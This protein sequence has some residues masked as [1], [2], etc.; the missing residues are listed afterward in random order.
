MSDDA[1]SHFLG[2]LEALQ[3]QVI[4]QLDALN[5]RIE[6]TIHQ[7]LPQRRTAPERSPNAAATAGSVP[8]V[9]VARLA[10]GPQQP[11]AE[12]QAQQATD[13]SQ[14]RDAVDLRADGVAE[15]DRGAEK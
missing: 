9:E 6:E 5:E 15:Q 11:Q 2:E 4:L 1:A 13:G 7:F 10:D 3:E 14:D 12:K 8:A